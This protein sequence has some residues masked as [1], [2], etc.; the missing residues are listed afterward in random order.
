MPSIWYG[1]H[2][3]RNLY[4]WEKGF[5]PSSIAAKQVRDKVEKTG[6]EVVD[7]EDEGWPPLKD[8]GKS[9]V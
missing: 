2:L 6:K 3:K 1:F 5:K 7:L 4:N 9:N 8:K